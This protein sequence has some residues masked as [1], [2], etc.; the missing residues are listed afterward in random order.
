L[1]L[2]VPV[3]DTSATVFNYDSIALDL[4]GAVLFFGPDELLIEAREG[5]LAEIRAE[6]LRRRPAPPPEELP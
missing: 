3:S 6:T 2:S 5:K 1:S 4:P